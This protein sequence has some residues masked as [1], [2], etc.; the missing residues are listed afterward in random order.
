[1]SQTATD[2]AIVTIE[3]EQETAPKLSKGTNFNDLEW[4]LTH[5]SR[6][7]SRVCTVVQYAVL[8]AMTRVYEKTENST[9]CKYK[10]AKDMQT[11]PRI[12]D[13]VAELSYCA[14][15]EKNRLTQFWWGNRGSLSFFTHT[16]TH[17]YVSTIHCGE[18][19]LWGKSVRPSWRCGEK[20][21]FP[22]MQ[23]L[24]PHSAM[25]WCASL[26]I[27]RGAY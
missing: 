27:V 7:R 10:M 11:P 9:P 20:F 15:S 13:Y 18:S 2:T 21:R 12:Y 6:S 17:L 23:I 25:F 16:H 1:M 24:L 14:K 26:T 3:G 8:E 4:H 22:T 5:I 19:A